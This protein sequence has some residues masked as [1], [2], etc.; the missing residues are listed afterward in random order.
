MPQA[1]SLVA[2]VSETDTHEISGG[3]FHAGKASGKLVVVPSPQIN[4]TSHRCCLEP[5]LMPVVTQVMLVACLA[6]NPDKAE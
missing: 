2:H 3:T 1:G 5:S 6:S 4:K